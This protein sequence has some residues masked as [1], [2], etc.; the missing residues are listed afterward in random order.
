MLAANLFDHPGLI[1]IIV[2]VTLIRWLAQKAKTTQTPK[3]EAP[4]SRPIPRGGESQTEEERVRK[5]LEALGQPPGSTPPKVATRRQA[6]QPRIFPKLPPLTTAPPP[7][8]Q[9]SATRPSMPPPLPLEVTPFKPA[10]A[11]EGGFEVHEVARQ[12]SSEPVPE[13]RRELSSR[14]NLRVNLTTSS[15]LRDAIV[16]REIFGPPR[17]VQ[18]L[19]S[20]LGF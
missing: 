17:S 15:G 3:P 10:T 16:L 11:Q 6:V 12:T 13:I 14:Q 18:P 19:D 7:L 5:F 1:L 4:P 8:S 2:A 20:L 9:P